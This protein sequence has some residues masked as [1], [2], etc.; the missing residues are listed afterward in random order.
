MKGVQC[1][2]LFGGVALKNHAFS[3]HTQC[4]TYSPVTKTN[5]NKHMN[6]YMDNNEMYLHDMH[7][8]DSQSSYFNI[9]IDKTSTEVNLSHHCKQKHT[10]KLKRRQHPI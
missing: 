4:Q 9:L 1:Y 8:V 5:V 2:E 10:E 3:F 6:I 7:L